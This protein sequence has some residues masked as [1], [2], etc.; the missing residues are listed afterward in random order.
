MHTSLKITRCLC[1]FVCLEA[2]K[3][4]HCNIVGV[5]E[6][7]P[8]MLLDGKR[9]FKVLMGSRMTGHSMPYHCYEQ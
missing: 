2:K 5:M 6:S 9:L 4:A 8:L 3:V 1:K 7:D